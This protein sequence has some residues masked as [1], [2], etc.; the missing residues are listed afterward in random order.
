MKHVMRGSGRGALILAAVLLAA[1]P[2]QAAALELKVIVAGI[3][4]GNGTI[5]VALYDNEDTFREEP[6]ARALVTR[7]AADAEAGEMTVV[8]EG[9]AAGDHAVIVTHDENDNGRMDRFLGMIP[10]EGYGLSNDP[11]VTGPPAFKDSAFALTAD[12]SVVVPLHY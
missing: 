4:H 10:T 1:A 8:F 6:Q 7:P 12:G 2:V 5:R 9:L 3:E 11:A